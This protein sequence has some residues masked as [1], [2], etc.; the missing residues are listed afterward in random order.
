MDII[1]TGGDIRPTNLLSY[2][3]R[4]ICMQM[5]QTTTHVSTKKEEEIVGTKK[6]RHQDRKKTLDYGLNILSSTYY[7]ELIAIKL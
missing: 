1:K 5:T 6:G 2:L 7:G 4:G 3:P